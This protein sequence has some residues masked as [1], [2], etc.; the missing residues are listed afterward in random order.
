[1]ITSTGSGSP[2]V[3]NLNAG[4]CIQACTA[5]TKKKPPKPLCHGLLQKIRA[6]EAFR[7][8]PLDLPLVFFFQAL[9]ACLPVPL[10]ADHRLAHWDFLRSEASVDRWI[11]QISGDF[12]SES[13]AYLPDWKYAFRGSMIVGKTDSLKNR[14]SPVISDFLQGDSPYIWHLTVCIGIWDQNKKIFIC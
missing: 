4:P 14:T 8:D 7:E 6:L 1:M 12:C 10:S 3:R 13:H 9:V 2:G 5:E 11:D